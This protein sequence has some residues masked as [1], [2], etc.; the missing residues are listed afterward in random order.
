MLQQ[1]RPSRRERRPQRAIARLEIVPPEI[2]PPEI[3]LREIKLTVRLEIVP[4]HG[5]LT[6][7][8]VRRIRPSGAITRIDL[9]TQIVR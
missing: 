8:I 3:A 5:A 1:C 6:K 9:R 4:R 2:V 7:P